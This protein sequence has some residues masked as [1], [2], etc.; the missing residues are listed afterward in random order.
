MSEMKEIIEAYNDND[1]P[2]HEFRGYCGELLGTLEDK[3]EHIIILQKEN[4][5]LREELRVTKENWRSMAEQ[6]AI[7]NGAKVYD[8][9]T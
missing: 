5:S 7:A 3:E 6:L 1:W 9:G 2:E 8:L 4:E